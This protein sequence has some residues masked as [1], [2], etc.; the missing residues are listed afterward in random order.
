MV[1]KVGVG[2]LGYVIGRQKGAAAVLL[3]YNK[4]SLLFITSHLARESLPPK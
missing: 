1:D 3:A 2:G 4:V